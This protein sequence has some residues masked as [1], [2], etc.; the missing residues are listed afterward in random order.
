MKCKKLPDDAREY[1]GKTCRG[2]ASSMYPKALLDACDKV[3]CE[4]AAAAGKNK[5]MEELSIP[6]IEETVHQQL[7]IYNQRVEA[8]N[9]KAKR[10]N[11]QLA[12]KLAR[13]KWMKLRRR[14][15]GGCTN[16]L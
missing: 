4:R 1:V 16:S 9:A 15:T 12:D 8:T 5:V 10:L 7:I 6:D 14:R 11:Q 3:F 13:G 2:D